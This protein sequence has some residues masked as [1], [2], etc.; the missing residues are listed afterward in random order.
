MSHTDTRYFDEEQDISPKYLKVVRGKELNIRLAGEICSP[1]NMLYTA[2]QQ[3]HGAVREIVN[4]TITYNEEYSKLRED[5]CKNDLLARYNGNIIAFEAQ[6]GYGKTQTMM[7]FS[8]LLDQLKEIDGMP[9]R[10][11]VL[12][13]IAPSALEEKQNLLWKHRAIQ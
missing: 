12:P 8:Y 4:Q 11:V 1:R 7:S 3:A 10:F 6:R 9:T 5:Y 13:M 2:Y